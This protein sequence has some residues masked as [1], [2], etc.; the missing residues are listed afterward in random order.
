MK[1]NI[2]RRTNS[3]TSL[4]LLEIKIHSNWTGRKRDPKTNNKC[5]CAKINIKKE[6]FCLLDGH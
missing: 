2:L 6:S 1:E 3:K 4:S 5:E